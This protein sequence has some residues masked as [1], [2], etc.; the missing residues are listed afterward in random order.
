[1]SQTT[2]AAPITPSTPKG[3]YTT[4]SPSG[5]D[6]RPSDMRTAG[7]KERRFTVSPGNKPSALIKNKKL[8]WRFLKH[9][10]T[11]PSMAGKTVA[12]TGTTTGTGW[13]LATVC[14]RQGARVIMLNRPSSRA[15]A[16]LSAL[17][18]EPGPDG[19]A[20]SAEHVDC[21]LTS[22]ASTRAAAASV[23]E[24]VGDG[25]LDVVCCNAGVMHWI[26]E[27]TGDGFDLQ[28]QVNQ[29]SHFLLVCELWP[30]L[31]QA[32]ELRGE[33][34]VVMHSSAARYIPGSAGMPGMIVPS[35]VQRLKPRFFEPH[36]AG[37]LGGEGCC[38][39]VT[40]TMFAGKTQERY[41][42]S[43]LANFVFA[44]AL[45]DKIHASAGCKVKSLVTHPGICTT[46]LAYN[47]TLKHG[48]V[49]KAL[50]WMFEAVVMQACE[51]GAL[52]IIRCS[53]DATVDNG[54]FFGPTC[55]GYPACFWGEAVKRKP[56]SWASDDAAQKELVWAKC[57]EACGV[58][59]VV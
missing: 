19:A 8:P 53:C 43:K 31:T 59:F 20:T 44:Y 35:C 26:D 11:L 40:M 17:Q 15:A 48:F 47:G 21:D 1:M 2:G 9:L 7:G 4:P 46:M 16:A 38:S 25:G 6:R 30:Q 56:E 57:E 29:I 41:Q 36:A 14:A 52:G 27:P 5:H 58:K 28:M 24:L 18:S 54:D 22:F 50:I 13:V 23:R 10:K 3:G 42:Q 55:P 37:G 51:D 49:P 33:A 39:S 32:G 34:R 12:I 45:R